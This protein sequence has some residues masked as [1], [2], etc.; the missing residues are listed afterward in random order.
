MVYLQNAGVKPQNEMERGDKLT[1]CR[2]LT[3]VIHLSSG[4]KPQ[5]YFFAVYE[6][7]LVVN[8]EFRN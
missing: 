1:Y 4:F 3:R 8:M 2:Y 6:A 5:K 7:C